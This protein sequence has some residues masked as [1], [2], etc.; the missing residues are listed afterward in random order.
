MDTIGYDVESSMYYCNSRY[1]NPE[2][3]RWLTPNDVSYFES[4]NING[5]NLYCYCYNN[6]VNKYDSS[7]NV[8]IGLA[9]AVGINAIR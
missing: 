3:G 6:P 2:C 9:I 1:Y 7:G 8:A 5:L 4:N